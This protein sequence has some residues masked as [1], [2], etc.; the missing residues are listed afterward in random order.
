MINIEE[1]YEVSLE[2]VTSLKE[3]YE[4]LNERIVYLLSNNER[5]KEEPNLNEDA[6]IALFNLNK[7]LEMINKFIDSV[8]EYDINSKYIFTT[9]FDEEFVKFI[10]HLYTRAENELEY[11][12]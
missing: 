9:M 7:V 3:K 12:K 11:I 1:A 6:H 10:N 2:E 5:F 4:M 8:D